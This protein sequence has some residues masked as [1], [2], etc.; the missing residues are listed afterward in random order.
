MAACYL[1]TKVQY[2]HNKRGHGEAIDRRVLIAATLSCE[3]RKSRAR[4]TE[5]EGAEAFF[6]LRATTTAA[7]SMRAMREQLQSKLSR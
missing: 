1:Q 3:R 7:D 6:P 5:E 4:R 2:P